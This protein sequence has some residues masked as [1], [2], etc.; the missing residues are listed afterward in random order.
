MAVVR[1]AFPALTKP[2]I[3]RVIMPK[4]STLGSFRFHPTS[5][6]APHKAGAPHAP[7]MS[8][9]THRKTLSAPVATHTTRTERAHKNPHYQSRKK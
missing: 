9:T 5:G 8:P 6:P 4:K 3:R 1:P 2:G 7:Q